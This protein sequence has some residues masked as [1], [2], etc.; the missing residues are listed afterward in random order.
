MARKSKK[1]FND[2]QIKCLQDQ[3][4]RQ[5]RDLIENRDSIYSLRE[6]VIYLEQV[7]STFI[8]TKNIR[9]YSRAEQIVIRN[10]L[11]FNRKD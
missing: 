9:E 7:V 4:D 10:S 11:E 5:N 1:E 3:I 8:K 2:W 6:R